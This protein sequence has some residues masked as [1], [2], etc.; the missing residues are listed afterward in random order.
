MGTFGIYC[1]GECHGADQNECEPVTGT[2]QSGSC[3]LGWI[4]YN[5]QENGKC[6]LTVK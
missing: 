1:K 3:E 5:C 2:C 4:G 6:T